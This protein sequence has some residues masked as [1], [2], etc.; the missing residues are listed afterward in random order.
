MLTKCGIVLAVI[1][2][3]VRNGT[4]NHDEH[5]ELLSEG[6]VDLGSIL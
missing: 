1:S 5:V 6:F 4:N 2:S 3:V